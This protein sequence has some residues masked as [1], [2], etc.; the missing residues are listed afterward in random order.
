[1][2]KNKKL[3]RIIGLIFIF[4]AFFFLIKTFLKTWKEVDWSIMEIK[5]E[6]FFPAIF[7][8]FLQF[9]IST[10]LWY[11]CYL[12]ILNIKIKFKELLAINTISQ[13]TKYIPGKIWSP[14]SAVILTT[15]LGVPIEQSIS[16]QVFLTFLYIFSAS[17]LS[18]I[19]ILIFFSK[20]NL[21]LLAL[22][23]SLICFITL[24][25]SIFNKIIN[26][27]SLKLRKKTINV[28]FSY[29][30]ILYLFFLFILSLFFHNLGCF[31]MLKAFFWNLIKFK[32]I[33][34]FIGIN[35]AALLI[36]FISLLP[37]GLG[38]RESITFLGLKSLFP[39]SIA[40]LMS[41]LIRLW[42]IGYISLFFFIFGLKFLKKYL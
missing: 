34:I 6:F 4:L 27:I 42:V 37:G 38:V 41:L 12:H 40:V 2:F 22:I 28:N 10:L 32:Q 18:L 24:H 39:T 35:T 9:L 20:T 3:L 5:Y 29:K 19:P 11:F 8:N 23:I 17:I 13:I 15:K 1:M 7:F 21:F 26:L 33:W 14:A 25:P 30:D 36:G 16:A 31:I